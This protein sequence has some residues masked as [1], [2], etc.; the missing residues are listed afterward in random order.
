M[1]ILLGD[2]FIHEITGNIKHSPYM[3]A[4]AMLR[5]SETRFSDLMEVSNLEQL[6]GGAIEGEKVW[7]DN[8]TLRPHLLYIIRNS[9]FMFVEHWLL[10]FGRW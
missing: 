8:Q 10:H 5:V 4:G 6:H 9:M 7:G 1:K 3:L 2:E